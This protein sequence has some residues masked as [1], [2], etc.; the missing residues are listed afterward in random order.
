MA[1]DNARGAGCAPGTLAFPPLGRVG[2]NWVD[3]SSRE[4]NDLDGSTDC[5]KG[6]V[7]EVRLAEAVELPAPFCSR[8]EM[9]WGGGWFAALTGAEELCKTERAM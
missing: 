4:S 2:S 8:A 3:P 6:V 7:V 5:E 9:S 1:C